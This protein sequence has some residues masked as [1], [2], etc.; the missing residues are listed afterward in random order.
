[1]NGFIDNIGERV[2]YKGVEY[3][4][5]KPYI[6]NRC[7]RCTFYDFVK[8]DCKSIGFVRNCSTNDFIVKKLKK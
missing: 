4:A 3:F 6:K 1:M 7:D 5:A 2:V 8:D